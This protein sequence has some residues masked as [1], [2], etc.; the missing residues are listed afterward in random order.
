MNLQVQDAP[1]QTQK[2]LSVYN[3]LE[4]SGVAESELYEKAVAKWTE[5][6][7][8]A[9]AARSS[10]KSETKPDKTYDAVEKPNTNISNIFK[11]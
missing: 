6:N 9:K 2:F 4:K 5:N 1:S 7:V 11:E 10:E 8:E 3:E